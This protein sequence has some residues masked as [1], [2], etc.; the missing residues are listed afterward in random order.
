MSE[1]VSEYLIHDG[2][3]SNVG[4]NWCTANHKTIFWYT[5]PTLQCILKLTRKAEKFTTFPFSIV[6]NAHRVTIINVK[7][8]PNWF[9]FFKN[10]KKIKN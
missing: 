6:S 3:N 2:E 1:L 5:N 8:S 7:A 4:Q 9:R 10:L